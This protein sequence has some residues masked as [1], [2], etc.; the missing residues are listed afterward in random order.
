MSR[1]DII[2]TGRR[3][4]FTDEAKLRIV[5][6]GFSGDGHQ[7]SAT[8]LK[9]GVSRSQLYRWRQLLREGNFGRGRIEGFVPAVVMPEAPPADAK[10]LSTATRMEIVNSPE[11]RRHPRVTFSAAFRTRRATASRF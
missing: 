11:F 10:A 6:E 8:A 7:V 5:E 4:R 2:E 9:H 1:L 3:R